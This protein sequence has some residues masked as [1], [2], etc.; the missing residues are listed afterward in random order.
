MLP[1]VTM[2]YLLLL[3]LLSTRLTA[4]QEVLNI[5]DKLHNNVNL[6]NAHIKAHQEDHEKIKPYL[7]L[8]SS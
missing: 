7:N 3:L 5:L 2:R 6:I 4:I 1:R 8:D